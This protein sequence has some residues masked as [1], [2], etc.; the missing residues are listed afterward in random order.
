[1]EKIGKV[2]RADEEIKLATIKLV[3]EN[4]LVCKRFKNG[5]EINQ[6]VKCAHW[7]HLEM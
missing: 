1:M 7:F 2:G 6:K 3:I 4:L 5:T